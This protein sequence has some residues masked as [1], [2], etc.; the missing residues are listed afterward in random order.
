MARIYFLWWALLVGIGITSVGRLAFSIAK[1]RVVS[2]GNVL[3]IMSLLLV[4]G[5]GYMCPAMLTFDYDGIS[6]S[7]NQLVISWLLHTA[8]LST[9][10]ISFRSGSS[11]RARRYLDSR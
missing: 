10:V 9:L 4:A 7:Q 8:A 3:L 6:C 2:A 11:K 5:A 1:G